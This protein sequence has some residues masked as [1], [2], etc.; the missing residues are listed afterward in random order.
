MIVAPIAVRV[1][2]MCARVRCYLLVSGAR[3]TDCRPALDE[4]RIRVNFHPYDG[5][6]AIIRNIADLVGLPYAE[7][8]LASDTRVA[9]ITA[10]RLLVDL[11]T[12][13]KHA[14]L[15]PWR[16]AGFGES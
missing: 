16:D 7:T 11:C 5:S 8:V 10:A 15:I 9:R 13:D 6:L 14:A 2:G 1:V 4:Q 3:T 12:S